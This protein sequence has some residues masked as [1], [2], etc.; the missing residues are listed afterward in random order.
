MF[1]FKLRLWLPLLPLQELFRFNK[2]EQIITIIMDTRYHDR[3]MLVINGF[4]WKGVTCGV[5]DCD[6]LFIFVEAKKF[7]WLVI[8]YFFLLARPGIQ[9]GFVT[10]QVSSVE[11]EMLTLVVHPSSP[12]FKRDSRKYIICLSVPDEGYSRNASCALNFIP[13]L[14]FGYLSLLLILIIFYILENKEH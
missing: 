4:R 14:L 7:S 6:N 5:N 2:N 8:C 12:L 1:F 10:R 9:C 13:T 11:E 3:V